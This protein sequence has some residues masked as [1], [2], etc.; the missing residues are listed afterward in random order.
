MEALSPPRHGCAEV[1]E[2]LRISAAQPSPPSAFP[3]L[4]SS[5]PQALHTLL[6]KPHSDKWGGG[7]R[8]S[9][10]GP[11]ALYPVARGE[12]S[13]RR[14]AG[15]PIGRVAVLAETAAQAPLGKAGLRCEPPG[16][17]SARGALHGVADSSARSHAASLHTRRMSGTGG[18]HAKEGA[19]FVPNR[20][21]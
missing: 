21:A 5:L 13:R 7:V 15:V 10:G 14:T 12:C 9:L 2:V 11:G 4:M 18:P 6:P 1:L 3:L 19:D 20:T 17:R 8:G 16:C